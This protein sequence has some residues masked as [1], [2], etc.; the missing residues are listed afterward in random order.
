LCPI[1]SFWSSYFVTAPKEKIG[2]GS[3]SGRHFSS[4]HL[5]RLDKPGK[6]GAK[7]RATSPAHSS[8]TPLRLQPLDVQASERLTNAL[9][10]REEYQGKSSSWFLLEAFPVT[11]PLATIPAMAASQKN[12]GSRPMAHAFALLL[13]LLAAV[14]APAQARSA[15]ENRAGEKSAQNAEL[16]LSPT[17]QLL[18]LQ[19]GNDPPQQYD[20]PGDSFAPGKG[21]LPD[22]L[23]ARFEAG[24]AFNKANRGRYQYNE[25]EVIVKGQKYRVDS[26]NPGEIV[27]RRL[28]QLSE[29][30]EQTAVGYF[31]EFTRKYPAGAKITDSPFNPKVLRGQELRGELIFEVPVQT[32]PIPQAVL[33][34]ATQH[35]N[36]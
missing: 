26:L 19:W 14:A 18:E 20:A 12:M 10:A 17:P 22:W 35:Q 27:S 31:N 30:Q 24:E 9:H 32:K 1:A 13:L 4:T 25:V 16:L 8:S 34:A 6:Q 2:S 28:T 3:A 23:K 29:V 7:E 11:L 5:T 33:D 15:P 21:S 36:L